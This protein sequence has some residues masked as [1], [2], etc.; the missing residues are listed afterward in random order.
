MYPLGTLLSVQQVSHAF[1]QAARADRP[2]RVLM[3]RDFRNY[4]G[5][6]IPIRLPYASEATQRAVDRITNETTTH[7]WQVSSLKRER[8]R[9]DHAIGHLQLYK[10]RKRLNQIA[11]TLVA[12]LVEIPH[13]KLTVFSTL[14]ALGPQV[15]DG[16]DLYT[17]Q[18]PYEHG[19]HWLNQHW[20][21][22]EVIAAIFRVDACKRWRAINE[23]ESIG[24]TG[25][26]RASAYEDALASLA[27]IGHGCRV[28][29]LAQLELLARDTDSFVRS[30]M[31]KGPETEESLFQLRVLELVRGRL[32]LAGYVFPHDGK[33]ENLPLSLVCVIGQ[34]CS[35]ESS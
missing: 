23:G 2:W 3:S 27:W 4:Q 6:A 31:T 20:W 21:S 34:I 11:L 35:T 28:P 5:A 33:E 14:V 1:L 16:I 32:I 9:I 22:T 7:A 30:H 8:T 12:Y 15:V 10:Q 24:V 29:V 26:A 13:H 18:I 19:S 25:A 17:T